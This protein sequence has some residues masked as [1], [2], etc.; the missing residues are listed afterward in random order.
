M[1]C[2][3]LTPGKEA[4]RQMNH[5]VPD[6]VLLDIM[7]PQMDGYEVCSCIRNNPRFASIPV[8]MISAKD[9][10]EDIVHGLGVG[11]DDYISKPFNMDIVEAR[12]RAV[13][14]IKQAHD[15][16]S[17]LNTDLQKAYQQAEAANRAKTEFLANMS[18]ELRTPLNAIIGFTQGMLDRIAK[19]PL[20]DHQQ[21]RMQ[22]ILASGHHLLE[23]IN[24][25]L[26]IAKVESGHVEMKF[27]EVHVQPV[28]KEVVDCC[29]SL[30]TSEKSVD[31]TWNAP[32][33]PIHL[34]TDAGKL[35]QILLN[36][37]GNSCKFTNQG[38]IHVDL[39][40]NAD[41]VI[42]QIKDTGMGI[43]AET[44][45]YIFDKFHQVRDSTLDSMK[46]TGLGLS[47]CRSY[48]EMMKGSINVKS[49]LN[50]GSCFTIQL[51]LT[52]QNQES[53]HQ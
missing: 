33:L 34:T 44:L 7:M 4:L 50:A 35:K 11:A 52:M 17:E 12:I 21:D 8:I 48:I 6:C 26:D 40:Q 47:I 37:V 42:I 16:L 53:V 1:T 18:H 28:V 43:P 15:Q 9:S 45:P 14:R 31:L 41:S 19:H 51:P 46:G 25:V 2:D 23:L 5:L 20:S 30:I 29:S 39:Q 49:Q 10:I 27:S 3:M 36:I 24:G 38:S 22:K 13:L 32:E